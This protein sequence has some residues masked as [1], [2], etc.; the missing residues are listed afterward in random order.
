MARNYCSAYRIIT[1]SDV[2]ISL[3]DMTRDVDPSLGVGSLHFSLAFICCHGVDNVVAFQP[4][5]LA[6]LSTPGRVEMGPRSLI[7]P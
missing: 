6:Y 7:I 2:V 1:P 4:Q 5:T 3:L